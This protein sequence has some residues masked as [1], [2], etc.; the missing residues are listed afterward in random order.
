MRGF[1]AVE[2]KA[3][4]IDLTGRLPLDV[5][6]VAGRPGLKAGQ[7][8]VGGV[9]F[10]RAKAPHPPVAVGL[11]WVNLPPN[12]WEIRPRPRLRYALLLGVLLGASLLAL[13]ERNPFLYVQF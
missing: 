2:V 3:Q 1:A 4:G 7:G 8:D 10:P 5:D 12:S 9:E 6:G 11:L 13:G